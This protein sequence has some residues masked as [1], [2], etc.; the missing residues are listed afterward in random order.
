MSATA[1]TPATCTMCGCTSPWRAAFAVVKD[2]TLSRLCCPAC[3]TRLRTRHARANLWVIAVA[4]AL[5]PLMLM[6]GMKHG[7]DLVVVAFLMFSAWLYLLVIPHELGHAVAARL[8]RAPAFAIQVGAEPWLLDRNLGGIRW[9]IG[10]YLGGGVTY[11]LPCDEGRLRARAI[12]IMLGGPLANLLIAAVAF[13]LAWIAPPSSIYTLL[14]LT[15][16]LAS[17]YQLVLN[18]WPRKFTLP[19]GEML[20]DGANILRQ[21]R[22]QATD[23]RLQRA[24]AH[25]YRAR[26][27]FD[28]QD[29]ALAR[30]AATRAHQSAPNTEWSA[31]LA[32]TRAAACSESDDAEGAIA[33]L[34][35]LM[36]TESK[37]DGVRAGICDNL[38][39]AYLLRDEPELLERGLELVA[40]A[41]HIAPWDRSYQLTRICL[42]AASANP[43]NARLEQATAILEKLRGLQL[44]RQNAAYA[45]LARGLVA[46]ARGNPDE[47]RAELA[48]AQSLR[49][50]AA[51]LRVLE[52]RLASR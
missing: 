8:V 48:N 12:F 17:M 9:R 22:G 13:V 37:E 43:G 50:T 36:E 47:A 16:G 51:P 40:V 15:L 30:R 31:A 39:W 3:A 14:W 35:P 19:A 41:C 24:A 1:T 28:D 42:L 6:S 46:A 26:I 32:V 34:L 23:K 27:A 21:L 5:L 20:S 2:G 52:R 11:H 18:L 45:A 33:L 44:Q 25:Y 7:F 38:A 10:K 49:A 29:F 4:L